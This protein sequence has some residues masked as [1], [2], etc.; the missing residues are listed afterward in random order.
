M[1]FPLAWHKY[2]TENRFYQI[3]N[4]W[5]QILYL[6]CLQSTKSRVSNEELWKYVDED[7]TVN[8]ERWSLKRSGVKLKLLEAVEVEAHNIEPVL[9]NSAS[10]RGRW[11]PGEA[12]TEGE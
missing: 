5:H 3:E 6:F 1:A 11:Q 10:L 4:E 12:V 2:E 9:H 7:K 8:S